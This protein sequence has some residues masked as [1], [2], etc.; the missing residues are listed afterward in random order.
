MSFTT[1]WAGSGKKSVPQADPVRQDYQPHGRPWGFCFL[2]PR[3][4]FDGSASDHSADRS[5]QPGASGLQEKNSYDCPSNPGIISF[6]CIVVRYILQTDDQTMMFLDR[7]MRPA[8]E[9]GC[10]CVNKDVEKMSWIY[11]FAK[12][13]NSR[14]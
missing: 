6:D 3:C 2:R 5:N 7:G 13:S 12:I 4:I 1:R 8:L 9:N 14:V 10:R 11:E